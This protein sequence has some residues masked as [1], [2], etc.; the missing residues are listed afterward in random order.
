MIASLDGTVAQ[1]SGTDVV[2]EVNGVGYRVYLGPPTL[3]GVSAG[4]R[5]KL[6]TH[7]LVRED[8]QALYGHFLARLGRDGHGR[9]PGLARYDRRG[10]GQRRGR[11]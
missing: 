6:H 7:H 5:L 4:Q 11:G 3:A 8:I 2:L 10:R 1:V 9:R